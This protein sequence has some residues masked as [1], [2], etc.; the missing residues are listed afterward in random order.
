MILKLAK[1][2]MTLQKTL[3]NQSSDS[4]LIN[5]K[6]FEWVFLNEDMKGVKDRL[7]VFKLWIIS[8]GRAAFHCLKTARQITVIRL[9]ATNY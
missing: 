7:K 8:L 1:V 6:I 4:F 9:I 2:Q 3:S 5:F